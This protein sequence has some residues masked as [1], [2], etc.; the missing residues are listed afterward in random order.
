M[1]RL[2]VVVREDHGVALGLEPA[3]LGLELLV[4]QIDFRLWTDH[5]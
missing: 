5:R 2:L 1:S 3:D 4:R